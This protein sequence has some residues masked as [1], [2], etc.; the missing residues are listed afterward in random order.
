MKR[1]TALSIVSAAVALAGLAPAAWGD[2]KGVP[3]GTLSLS[4]SGKT[5]DY[6]L[7]LPFPVSSFDFNFRSSTAAV[8]EEDKLIDMTASGFPAG[9]CAPNGGG[10]EY[11]GCS[12]IPTLGNERNFW[13]TIPAN[14]PIVGHVLMAQLRPGDTVYA[15]GWNGNENPFVHGNTGL[16]VAQTHE[17]TVGSSAPSPPAGRIR[18]PKLTGK[19]LASAESAIR[20]AGLKVGTIRRARSTRVGRGH[21]ISQS[22]SPGRSV[23]T[24]TRV[25]LVVS[26]GT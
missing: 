16:P 15:L 25:G 11:P 6:T 9:S 24:G 14:T 20:R 1:F 2:F 21:V 10:A 22:V 12:F 23:A 4:A 3:Y 26:A 19:L 5:L 7:T 18:M 17:L 8:N 13:P